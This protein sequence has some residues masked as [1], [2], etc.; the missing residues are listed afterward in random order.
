LTLLKKKH[1]CRR[2]EQN[3]AP[4]KSKY[5]LDE[6]ILS[7]AQSVNTGLTSLMPNP[8]E[9]WNAASQRTGKTTLTQPPGHCANPPYG[10]P[11][12]PLPRLAGAWQAADA[13]HVPS[14]APTGKSLRNEADLYFRKDEPAQ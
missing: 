11:T 7:E 4:Q 9:R 12:R 3:H 2:I 14:D 10:Q 13:L 1:S 5:S 6:P 8:D